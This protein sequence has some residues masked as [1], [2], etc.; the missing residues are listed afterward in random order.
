MEPPAIDFL[1]DLIAIPG[2]SGDE[3][4][5]ADFLEARLQAADTRP[6]GIALHRIGDNLIALRGVPRTAIFAHTDTVGFT[7]GYH[8]QLIRVGSPQPEDR[9]P[10]RCADGLKGRLRKR[11]SKNESRWELRRVRDAEGKK[12]EP[13]P[14][15]RWVYA[16]ET[17]VEKGIVTSPY[18]DDRAGVWAAFRALMQCE[19]IAVAFCVGEEQHGHGARG[20]ADYLYRIHN[21]TQAL[22]SDITWDTKDTPCGKGVVVSIRDAFSPRQRFLDRVLTLAKESGIS[23][24][25]EIQS[26]GSSDGGHI[27]RSAVPMD[28][29]FIGAPEKVPH[30]SREQAHVSDLEA[31]ADLL[32]YLVDRL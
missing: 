9:E 4:A 20:C 10:L 24:Q 14:G 31:M 21:I 12:A 15:T 17:T 16:R 28:W 7:L 6:A 2:V 19:N 13:A 8:R 5:A 23:H 26:A 22:I 18:L 1:L 3:G 30:T 27:L 25:T 29:V 32:T 11:G